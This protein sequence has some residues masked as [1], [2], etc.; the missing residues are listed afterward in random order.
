MFWILA[1]VV[2]VL[3]LAMFFYYVKTCCLGQPKTTAKRRKLLR[4]IT[5]IN[6]LRV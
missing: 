1:G 4:R 3:Y 6:A 5:C 2:D